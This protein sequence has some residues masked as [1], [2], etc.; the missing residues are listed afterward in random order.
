MKKAERQIKRAKVQQKVTQYIEGC[1]TDLSQFED[2]TFDGILCLGEPLSHLLSK[3]DRIR[4]VDELIRVAKP[5]A[6]L[7]V[8]V[9]GRLVVLKDALESFPDLLEIKDLFMKILDTGTY[10]GGHGFTA[11]HFFLSEELESIFQEKPVKILEMVGLEGLASSHRRRLNQLAR[12][13]PKRWKN[14]QA[15]HLKTCT[16]AHIVG[17]SNH[18]L[19][20]CQKT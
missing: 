12:K 8:S 13:Y 1:I 9:I 6:P 10:E 7:F 2:N 15:Y 11:V 20:I 18:I 14:W 5:S 3:V 4:A 19:L 16:H 17:T